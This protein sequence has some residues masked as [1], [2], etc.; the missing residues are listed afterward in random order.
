MKAL[1]IVLLALALPTSL[2]ASQTDWRWNFSQWTPCGVLGTAKDG[3]DIYDGPCPSPGATGSVFLYHESGVDGWDGETNAYYRDIRS[4]LTTAGQSKTW[5]LYV[6]APPGDSVVFSWAPDPSHLP[7][8]DQI[9]Y[10]ITYMRCAVGEDG[11]AFSVGT[12]VVMNNQQQGSWQFPAYHTD[13]YNLD[14]LRNGY[15]VDFTATLVP[16]PSSLLALLTGL[17]GLGAML[18]RRK[19]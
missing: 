2:M 14:A 12:T 11:P 1:I 13:V 8:F 18:R 10:T 17:G 16:E 6:V 5:R 7:A 15:V 3:A 9:Q 19:R 4:P